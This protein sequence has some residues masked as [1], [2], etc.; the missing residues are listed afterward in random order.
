MSIIGDAP[1]I[2]LATAQNVEN[3]SEEE[4]EVLREQDALIEDDLAPG[5][6]PVSIDLAE[7][8]LALADEDVGL[9][10]HAVPV[11]EETA[12]DGDLRR[13]WPRRGRA[14]DLDVRDHVADPRR[15]LF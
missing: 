2:P 13:R 4:G 10:L 11:D 14:E 15:R 1:R 5:D 12:L 6:P 8:A 7:Q 3:G 9:R